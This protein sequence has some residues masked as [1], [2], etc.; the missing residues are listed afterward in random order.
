MNRFEDLDYPKKKFKEIEE[1]PSSEDEDH[2]ILNENGM[3]VGV[4]QNKNYK[5]VII[6]EKKVQEYIMESFQE[7][8][9]HD[10]PRETVAMSQRE[11]FIDPNKSRSKSLSKSK[12]NVTSRKGLIIQSAS[13]N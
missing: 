9:H 10:L 13:K 8:E 11:S 1:I 6:P 4:Y 7:S 3:R 2:Y 12:S 5:Q